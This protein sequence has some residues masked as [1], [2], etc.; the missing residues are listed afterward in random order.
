M[1]DIGRYGDGGLDGDYY[2]IREGAQ[3]G[4]D[5]A[6]QVYIDRL[7]KA[8]RVAVAKPGA[9]TEEQIA[10]MPTRGE[11]VALHLSRAFERAEANRK[12]WLRQRE[13]EPK[14]EPKPPPP[15]RAT[16]RFMSDGE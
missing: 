13:R 11:A 15:D 16:E 3:F 1:A 7:G 4:A 8:S 10:E 14:P 6:V 9:W 5:Q 2:W 12:T